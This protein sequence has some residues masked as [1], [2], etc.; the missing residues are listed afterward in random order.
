M[1]CPNDLYTYRLIYY[2]LFLIVVLFNNI[3][4]DLNHSLYPFLITDYTHKL[5]KP[6]EILKVESGTSRV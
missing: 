6:A 1:G 2:I 4:K 5:V 3:D